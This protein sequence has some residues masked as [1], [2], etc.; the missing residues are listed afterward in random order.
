MSPNTQL[1]KSTKPEEAV[2]SVIPQGLLR[3]LSVSEIKPSATNPRYLFDRVPLD[4][5][6]ENIRLHG[7]LVPITVYEI[8]EQR[9]F[10]ILDGER[11]YRC[12]VELQDEGLDIAIPANIVEPPDKIAGILYMFSIHNFREGWEL[13]PTALSLKVVMDALGEQDTSKLSKL[14][15][16]SEPQIERCKILLSIPKKFQDLSLDPDPSTRIPSNFWIEASPVLDLCKKELPDLAM[17]IGRDGLTELLVEKY[18]NKSIKSVIHFRRILEAYDI[19]PDNESHRDDVIDRLETYVTNVQMETRKAFDE[20][21]LDNRR[22]QGS[23]KA[24]EDFI[25]QLERA[26]LEHV[27]ENKE[28]LAI[29]LLS[30]KK[31]VEELLQK[32]EG[33][34]Q[35]NFEDHSQEDTNTI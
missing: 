20:F 22:I 8:K 6:K 34:D 18:R 9:K 35:P 32:L 25:S 11:R 19:H 23:I 4:E 33:S 2:A 12:C 28:E 26:K 15:G 3:R 16:L 29:A 27:V 24:C 21:V 30:V 10:A 17:K 14:T 31:Y 1:K 7:V 5:L 13:M